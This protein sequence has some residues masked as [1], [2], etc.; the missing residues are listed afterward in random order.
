[1]TKY[2]N[3]IS[4]IS[5]TVINNIEVKPLKGIIMNNIRRDFLKKVAAAGL[6]LTIGAEAKGRGQRQRGN[7]N[8]LDEHQLDELFYIYQEEKVAR[9]VY[10]TL[11]EKYTGENTFASIQLSE[12]RHIDAA[13]GLCDKYKIDLSEVNEQEVGNFVV[14]ELQDL[15]DYCITEGTKGLSEALEIGVLVEETDIADLTKAIKDMNMPDDVI[16]VYENLREGSY[17]HLEAFQTALQRR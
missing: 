5:K 10:I 7:G 12:Q 3:K 1:M 6:V 16:R 2:I 17:N 15:Y 14:P 8:S 11:G 4:K 13:Q 9:D